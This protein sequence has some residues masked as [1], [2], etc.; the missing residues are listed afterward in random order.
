LK[1]QPKIC[2]F[3]EILF[4]MNAYAEKVEI[5]QWIAGLKDLAT[6]KQLKKIKEQSEVKQQ[7][8]AET[9]SAQERESIQRGIED[10]KNGRI[11]PHTEVRKRYEKWL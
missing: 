2:N 8:L 9:I 11:T 1:T 4:I 7:V 5:I 3:A 6:L 10:L